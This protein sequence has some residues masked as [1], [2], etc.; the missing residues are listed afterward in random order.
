MN[1]FTDDHPETTL[2][3]L[4]FKTPSLAKKSILRVENHFN[5]ILAN[6]LIP[7]NSGKYRPKNKF[8]TYHQAK[9]YYNNQKMTRVLALYN[10][11]KSIIKKTN[12]LQKQTKLKQSIKIL[13]KW[14]LANKIKKN[15]VVNC[16]LS[17]SNN[18][19]CRRAS[20][21]KIFKLPR[22][23]SKRKCQH[24]RGFTMKSSCAPYLNCK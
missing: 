11:S 6:Q 18:K 20:D 14:I 10:R 22:K 15:R 3:G 9:R 7:G 13:K 12:N 2:H 17:T 19:Q 16:C 1:L 21:G 4:S 23:F 24:P 8:K 5:Q